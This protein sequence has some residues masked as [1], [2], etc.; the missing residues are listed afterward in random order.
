M[1]LRTFNPHINHNTYHFFFTKFAN[2][3][4]MGIILSL[5]EKAKNVSEITE[6]LH[7]EQSK[8]SH[9]LASLKNCRIINAE[10]SGKQ[11]IYSLNKDTVVPLLRIADTHT[12]KYCKNNC[13]YV[14]EK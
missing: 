1:N 11:R 3:L 14:N 12:T 6:E 13:Y 4:K 7:V 8:I 9:A 10:Q 2:P 5:N